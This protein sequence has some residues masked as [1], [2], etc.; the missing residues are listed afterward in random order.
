M[1]PMIPAEYLEIESGPRPGMPLPD[2]TART[3]RGGLTERSAFASGQGLVAFL[4]IGCGACTEQ[5]PQLGRYVAKERIERAL[6]LVVVNGDPGGQSQ[7]A[8]VASTFAQVVVEAADGPLTRVFD[9]KAF[10]TVLALHDGR[11]EAN[12]PSVNALHL[13]AAR[14]HARS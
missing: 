14:T 1:Q 13:E 9:I 4:S 3:T 7:Y 2:F 12:A 6:S 8:S 5:L 11:V 10:P